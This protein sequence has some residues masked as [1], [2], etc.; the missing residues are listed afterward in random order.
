[1]QESRIEEPVTE[2]IVIVSA[3]AS[4]VE[5]AGGS[6]GLASF[7]FLYARRKFAASTRA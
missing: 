1:L 4:P 7:R 5:R 6:S 3:S 2:G